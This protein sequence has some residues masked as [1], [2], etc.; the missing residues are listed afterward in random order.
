[1]Y[2]RQI[3]KCI[4]YNCICLWKGYRK[5]H[6][7]GSRLDSGIDEYSLE[8]YRERI[9]GWGGSLTLIGG[10]GGSIGLSAAG[11]VGEIKGGV[12]VELSGSIGYTFYIGNIYDNG[13]ENE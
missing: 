13:D 3:W 9:V 5:S 1:M 8:G 6:Y 10:I 11:I 4:R 2:N 7:I 12:E